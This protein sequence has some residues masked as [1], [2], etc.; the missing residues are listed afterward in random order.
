[1]IDI[2]INEIWFITGSQH[3]YGAKVLRKV[4]AHTEE[5]VQSLNSN[6]EILVSIKIR[7]LLTLQRRLHLFVKFLILRR[8]VLD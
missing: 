3:L 1:M 6:S 4:A 2:S 7:E 8:I 5:I